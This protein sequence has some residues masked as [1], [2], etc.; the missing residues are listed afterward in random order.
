MDFRGRFAICEVKVGE[1]NLH[2]VNVYA[3]NKK[4]NKNKRSMRVLL[5]LRENPYKFTHK[6][7]T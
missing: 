7:G 2:L 3:P 6:K 1:E 4:I 5:R